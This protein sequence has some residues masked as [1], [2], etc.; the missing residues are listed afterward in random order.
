MSDSIVCLTPQ[1]LVRLSPEDLRPDMQKIAELIP[2]ILRHG[3]TAYGNPDGTITLYP[4][5]FGE[6]VICSQAAL[7]RFLKWADHT[8]GLAEKLKA[9][10]ILRKY[11]SPARK[12]QKY[13]FWIADLKTH[14]R[15]LREISRKPA[16]R[17]RRK[18]EDV[19]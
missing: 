2:F 1:D 12:G 6:P 3:Y 13:Q 18:R 11:V 16:K 10:G 4:P 9:E 15:A 19:E 8:T 5:G 7:A 14:A 17:P